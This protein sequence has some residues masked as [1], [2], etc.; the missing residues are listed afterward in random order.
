MKAIFICISFILLFH[1]CQKYICHCE[2]N[3]KIQE[4]NEY[5]LNHTKATMNDP[6]SI[7]YID[8]VKLE[9]QG[10]ESYRFSYS[11]P[12]GE[13]RHIYRITRQDGLATLV[14]KKAIPS[15]RSDSLAVNMSREL[16]EPEWGKIKKV[17]SDNCFW[18]ILMDEGI[19]GLDGYTWVLEGYN[20]QLD[21]C[22]KS[23]YHF[24][25]RWSPDSKSQNFINICQEIMALD[26]Q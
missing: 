13:F 25:Y 1:G 15:G 26:S 21:P 3:P 4:R 12:Y 16:S 20:P 11:A 19:K 23:N 7:K 5:T 14:V 8:G 18:N 17:L 9:E 24:I 10:L 2:I 6:F 22:A